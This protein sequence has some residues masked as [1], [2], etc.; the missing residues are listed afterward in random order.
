MGAKARILIADDDLLTVTTTRM[1]LEHLGYEVVGVATDG[2]AAVELGRTRRPD[3]ILMDVQMPR[4]DGVQATRT[5]MLEQPA[6]IVLVSGRECLT[7][8][9]EQAGAM[10]C[11]SKPVWADQLATLIETARARFGRF[12]RVAADTASTEDA[13]RRWTP[14]Q[15][16]VLAESAA[17]HIT[18]EQAFA[19]LWPQPARR[20]AMPRART[21]SHVTGRRPGPAPTPAG[22]GV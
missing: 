13:L 10:G 6:C 11:A 16:A 22:N 15:R 1:L 2:A 9:A 19:R 21:R 4:L 7:D 18:E 20:V 5:L 3:V 17:R 14:L 8:L 12:L